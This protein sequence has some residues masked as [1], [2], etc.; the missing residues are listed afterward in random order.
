[1]KVVILLSLLLTSCASILNDKQ[2]KINIVSSNNKEI[3]GTI[4]G[5]PFSGPGIINVDREKL[6]KIISVDNPACTKQTIMP[7]SVDTAFFVNILSGGT[8]GSTTDY[9]TG[10][11]WKYQD[12]VVIQCN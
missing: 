3:K 2:Q 4:N 8:T 6:D 12:T 9:S 1:M 7:S 5:V 11:M 10:K